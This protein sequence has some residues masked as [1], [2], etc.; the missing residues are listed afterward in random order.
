MRRMRIATVLL[1]VTIAAGCGGKK[2]NP[3][4]T[5]SGSGSATT[6]TTGSGSSTAG[7][8]SGS[9]ATTMTG[10][11]TGGSAVAAGS[12]APSGSD[13]GS[14]SD[15]P[16]NYNDDPT[17]A[18]KAGMCP[19]TVVGSTTKAEVKGKAVVVIVTAT[20]PAAIT[21]IQKRGKELTQERADNLAPNTTSDVHDMKG[22]HGG[23]KGMCPVYVSE[24]GKMELK[25][26]PKGIAVTL[27]PKDKL[28]DLKTVIDGRIAK[29]A[30]W[31]K[32][33]EHD[34]DKG[35]GGT[36]GGSG[37][38]GMNHSGAGDGLGRSRHGGSGGGGQGTGGG[39]GMGTG[40]GSGGGT[41]GG[42]H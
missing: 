12:A 27:T 10:S 21:A 38:D 30:D 40:G 16:L 39:N 18:H 26:L 25:D 32:T 2:D 34:G 22:T 11:D 17:M 31:V 24:G 7:S 8:S 23:T 37:N 42:A 36:G 1:A 35:H 6:A 14:G 19:S 13:A 15:T 41:G 20:D 9:S 28:A 3:S 4:A 33:H 29:A 5:G